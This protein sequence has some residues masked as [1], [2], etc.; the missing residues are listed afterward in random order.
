MRKRVPGIII[1]S[2]TLKRTP[3][4]GQGREEAK[5]FRVSGI[6]LTGIVPIVSVEAEEELD[7]LVG[8]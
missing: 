4:T 3:K 2:Q 7:V 5:D 1:T 6:A 8:G